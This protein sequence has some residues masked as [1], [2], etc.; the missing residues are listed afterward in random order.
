[1]PG[2]P[3]ELQIQVAPKS[4]I[5]AKPSGVAGA[6]A[7]F[8][9]GERNVNRIMVGEAPAPATES[10]KLADAIETR[11]QGESPLETLEAVAGVPEPTVA[12]ASQNPLDRKVQGVKV[13]QE[14]ANT[15]AEKIDSNL[16]GI[17]EQC[18]K[19]GDVRA[20]YVE[21]LKLAFG[22]DVSDPQ[23]RTDAR[24]L[25]RDL[26]TYDALTWVD[27]FNEEGKSI[28]MSGGV[29]TTNN[30]LTTLIAPELSTQ[31]LRLF[32]EATIKDLGD[33]K[34]Q[35]AT[36]TI[37]GTISDP[38]SGVLTE[39][40]IAKLQTGDTKAMFA[41]SLSNKL[42]SIDASFADDENSQIA[43]KKVETGLTNSFTLK[44]ETSV[45][46][47]RETL[48]FLVNGKKLTPVLKTEIIMAQDM[49]ITA[50]KKR[51]HLKT[52]AELK[53]LFDKVQNELASSFE[54]PPE[55]KWVMLEDILRLEGFKPWKNN[56]QVDSLI[57]QGGL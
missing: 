36:A 37:D 23:L 2:K 34:F 41:K 10:V 38:D 54:I 45:K 7:R 32:A 14:Y 53:P 6:L 33:P 43:L 22:S 52:E 47:F 29:L 51:E 31:D 57:T 46:D 21:A 12:G 35:F 18:L 16:V 40:T 17:H 3:P 15:D 44:D 13:I 30:S 26:F 24:K 42:D 49:Q 11:P 55:S 27:V 39:E 8:K 25:I 50:G 28:K 48:E 5:T 9:A 56:I 4:A 20:A 19:D 1:M